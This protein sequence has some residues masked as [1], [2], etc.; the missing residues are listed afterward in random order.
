MQDFVNF[1]Y[2]GCHYEV[3]HSEADS[4]ENTN[5]GKEIQKVQNGE[6]GEI[7]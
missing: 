6:I 4:G 3:L 1:A 5:T 7:G 2:H